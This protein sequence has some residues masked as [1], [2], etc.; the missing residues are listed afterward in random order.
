MF[1]SLRE[2]SGKDMMMMMMMFWWGAVRMEE[3]E[4][5][6]MGPAVRSRQ[7]ASSSLR[8]G[9]LS[10]RCGAWLGKAVMPHGLHFLREGKIMLFPAAVC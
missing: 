6:Q 4:E 1:K 2:D 5:A 8:L 9:R 3:Q 7:E 10:G